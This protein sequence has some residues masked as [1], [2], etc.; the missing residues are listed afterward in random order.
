MTAAV[1]IAMAIIGILVLGMVSGDS[2]DRNSDLSLLHLFV[3]PVSVLMWSYVGYKICNEY[4][5]VTCAVTWGI[6]SPFIGGL[7]VGLPMFIIGALVGVLTAAVYYYVTVPI[8]V[9]TGLFIWLINRGAES[10]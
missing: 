1:S 3:M 5:G 6:F 8:G 9:A 2:A 4:F 7:L 10:I